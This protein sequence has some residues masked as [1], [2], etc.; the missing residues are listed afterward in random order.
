MTPFE[1]AL[2]ISAGVGALIGTSA[3]TFAVIYLRSR[4]WKTAPNRTKFVTFDRQAASGSRLLSSDAYREIERTREGTREWWDANV[5]ALQKSVAT[6]DFDT[7]DSRLFSSTIRSLRDISENWDRAVE[8]SLD[9]ELLTI[10]TDYL[11]DVV[12]RMMKIPKDILVEEAR[13]GTTIADE[14]RGQLHLIEA[15]VREIR[16][17]V[18]DADRRDVVL[19]SEIIQARYTKIES[20]FDDL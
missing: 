4:Y 20:A 16:R 9:V 19:N 1:I 18:F 15:R 12:E 10:V 17:S 5:N 2:V 6:W 3:G 7:E 8:S 11:P 14:L 13:D